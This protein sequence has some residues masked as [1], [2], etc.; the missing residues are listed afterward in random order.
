MTALGESTMQ[1]MQQEAT[2]KRFPIAEMFTSPQGE[3]LYTGTLMRFIRIAGCSVGRKMKDSEERG[4]WGVRE[5]A[6][7]NERFPLINIYREVC[8]TFDGREFACDT[9]FSTKQ[10]LTADEIANGVGDDIE[11]VCITGGEPLN[12]NLTQLLCTLQDKGCYVHI[13]T[14]GTVS[15]RNAYPNFV[16]SDLVDI[17][18]DGW[19]WITVSPKRGVLP[20]MI[21]LASEV[22][23]LIDDGFDP[24]CVSKEFRA[25]EL[26]YLQPI[27]GEFQ[28]SDKNMQRCLA[29]Q[30]AFPHFRISLQ[31]HK[32]WKVR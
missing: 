18:K 11:H 8:T 12:H 23:L 16:P 31:A 29:L 27:N 9:D 24:Y 15:I 19:L 2:Q 32:L 7:L 17:S 3:G 30:K 28:I 22:K 13:E 20:E 25:K 10:V 14:S 6:L 4:Q 21:S 26:V 1:H 5:E